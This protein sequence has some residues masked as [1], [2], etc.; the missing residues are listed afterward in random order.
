MEIN[1]FYMTPQEFADVVVQTL[2]DG[3]YFKK[4]QK[5]HPSDIETAFSSAAFAVASGMDAIVRKNV[6]KNNNY[7]FTPASTATNV[8][9]SLGEKID[10]LVNKSA[11]ELKKKG[12]DLKNKYT[13]DL[14]SHNIDNYSEWKKQQSKV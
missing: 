9:S 10:A 2:H 5:A 7:T 1:K 11:E 14:S 12:E 13:M 6:K 8:A 4:D 3:G